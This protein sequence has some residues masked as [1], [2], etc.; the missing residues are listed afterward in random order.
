M[1]VILTLGPLLKHVCDE[2]IKGDRYF[3]TFSQRLKREA[4]L[5]VYF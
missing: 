3:Q 2:T 4:F 1:G 5:L